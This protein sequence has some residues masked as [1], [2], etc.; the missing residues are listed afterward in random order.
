MASSLAV[1]SYFPQLADLSLDP[2]G[3]RPVTLG[4]QNFVHCCL[5][6]LNQ[7]LVVR[8]N[9]DGGG[10]GGGGNLSYADPSFVQ[11]GVSVEDLLF[12]AQNDEF[13]CGASFNGDTEGA[14]VVSGMYVLY[15]YV[16]VVCL[17]W[18]R[19]TVYK[20]FSHTAAF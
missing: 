15:V 4:G 17:L 19:S 3:P 6:A 16:F 14:P 11:P 9:D 7:S 20:R 1:A 2:P 10:G 18:L 13:P 8:D 12:A 5:I